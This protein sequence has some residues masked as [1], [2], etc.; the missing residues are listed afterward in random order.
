MHLRK[1]DDCRAVLDC[2]TTAD[3][4]TLQQKHANT[5]AVTTTFLNPKRQAERQNPFYPFI[6]TI[7]NFEVDIDN[8]DIADVF[9]VDETNVIQSISGTDPS[10]AYTTEQKAIVDLVQILDSFNAPDYA[11][12]KILDWAQRALQSGFDFHPRCKSRSA[13]V[14][15]MYEMLSK[16]KQ[17]LPYLRQ[18]DPIVGNPFDCICFDFVPQFLSLLQD[19]FVMQPEN[20]CIDWANPCSMYTPPDGMLGECNSG[21]VYRE[22]YSEYITDD[23]KQLLCPIIAYIDKTN[24]DQGSRFTLEPFMF[25]TSLFTEKA[26]RSHEF[27]KL[28]GYVHDCVSSSAYKKSRLKPGEALQIYHQQLDAI[29]ETYATA[30]AR[31]Q[32]VRLPIGPM[33]QTV[34]DLVC[35]LMFI[36]CDNEEADKLAGH[37]SSRTAGIQRPCRLCNVTFAD[38]DDPDC[39]FTYTTWNDVCV[40]CD[41]DND[42]LKTLSIHNIDNALSQLAPTISSRGLLGCL[43]PDTLHCLSKGPAERIM[44]LTLKHLT[45][46]QKAQL[47][48]IATSFHKSH[49]Q[50]ARKYFPS[51]DFSR[52]TDTTDG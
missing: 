11:L 5:T 35:P 28:F 8:Q 39:E 47:D 6:D 34:V 21:S 15:W 23:S 10:I 44:E 36:I 9:Q 16:S 43:L 51:T 42:Q 19:P 40:A 2:S 33:G 14:K 45:A 49:S 26:R 31:L 41:G 25:T 7:D 24:L 50:T 1:S 38:L 17:M 12:E 46:R 52:G 48:D 20:L 37:Y 4:A 30:S 18:V 22:M 13:N 3:L 29:L 27:W 32:N